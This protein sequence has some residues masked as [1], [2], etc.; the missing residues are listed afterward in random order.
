MTVQDIITECRA[1]VQQTNPNNSA[2]SDSTI[3]SYINACTLQLCSI[4]STLPKELVSAT[5]ASTITL[6]KSLLRVDFVS[7]ADANTI[8]HPLQTIDF[9]NFSRI[10]PEWQNQVAAQ[11]THFVRMTDKTWMLFPTPSAE[12]LGKTM[13]I[14]GAVQPDD[15]TQ[16]TE[17]PPV[18]IV[19]HP[20]Y[21]HY[22]A[23]KFFLAINNPERA[24]A[25]YG[26]FEG[27]RKLN[28]Q[29]AT[30]TTGSLLAFKIRG[31]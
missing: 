23:W 18:S 24:N 3:L 26:I 17:E 5:C 30:S 21:P 9:T 19:M 6:D 16:T 8:Y 31:N 28:T 14:Y 4:I 20:A 11:P 25:E 2:V 22:C 13:S 1:I 10:I 27:I 29:T 7:I 12:W 15:L